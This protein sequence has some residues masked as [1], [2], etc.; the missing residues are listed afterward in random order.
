MGC[1]RNRGE[2]SDTTKGRDVDEVAKLGVGL[3]LDG[4]Q[5]IAGRVSKN[6][7]DHYWTFVRRKGE[8]TV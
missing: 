7:P 3:G 2:G 1:S 8:K 4:V 6:G 5:A